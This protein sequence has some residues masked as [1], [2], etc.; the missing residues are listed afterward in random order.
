MR[1]CSLS[2]CPVFPFILFLEYV[3][4]VYRVS[5]S[6][7]CTLKG[8]KYGQ[9]A[10][11]GAC[12]KCRSGW[13]YS[14]RYEPTFA[15][16]YTHTHT[17]AHA[18]SL[19]HALTHTQSISLSYTHTHTSTHTHTHR[20]A[21]TDTNTHRRHTLF[22]MN[23]LPS[24]HFK[25]RVLASCQAISTQTRVSVHLLCVSRNRLRHSPQ[26]RS[27]SADWRVRGNSIRIRNFILEAL[28][29][30]AR[31]HRHMRNLLSASYS[32]RFGGMRACFA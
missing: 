29:E 28:A 6:R 10:R 25:N 14:Y 23:I 24:P 7:I 30:A 11:H 9:I 1:V 3:Y 21:H 22:H 27:R 31:S 26:P 19:T 32:W 16:K 13:R 15:Q 17:H 2:F 12:A 20:H 8:H 4:N 5:D 18:L